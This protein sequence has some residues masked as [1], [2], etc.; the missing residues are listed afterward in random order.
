[1]LVA[2]VPIPAIGPDP[3]DLIFVEA[4]A[5]GVSA[6]EAPI[7]DA[8]RQLVELILLER[9]EKAGANFGGGGNLLESDVALLALLF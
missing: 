3:D 1:M 4:Y 7:K 2:P 8:S 6:D 9:L 5:A